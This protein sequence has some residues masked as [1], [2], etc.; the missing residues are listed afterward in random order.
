VVATALLL[1]AAGAD[2]PTASRLFDM[3]VKRVGVGKWC[4]NKPIE[5]KFGLPSQIE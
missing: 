3:A 1:P 4:F 2:G 5:P